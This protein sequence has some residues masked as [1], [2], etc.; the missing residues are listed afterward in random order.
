MGNVHEI[1]QQGAPG[2][3]VVYVDNDPVAMLHSHAILARNDH[4]IAI[5]ADLRQPQ[6]L[7]NDPELRNLLDLSEPVALLL[8]AVLHFLP[9]SDHPASLVADLRDALAP[10]SY[11]VISHG[12]TDGQPPH[13]AEA[14]RQ[15]AQ[16]T[17]PFRPRS[18]AEILAFFDGFALIPPGL[19]PVPQW[20]AAQPGDNL[21]Q[22]DPIA[23]YG[24]A[25]IK[26]EP[27]AADNTPT[28]SSQSRDR[29]HR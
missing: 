9:D 25:G 14:M 15:Y 26:H 10:G 19:V 4:A 7:L 16:T 17:A 11:I 20:R 21:G 28:G 18:H 2:A 23:A 13:V 5:Q 6:Q 22:P 27:P 1:A 8:V 12:N 3:R 24:G 29:D